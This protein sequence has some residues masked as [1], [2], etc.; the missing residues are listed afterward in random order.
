L[1]YFP[2]RSHF[3]CSMAGW[4]QV[5]DTVLDWLDNPRSGEI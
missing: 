5:A 1:K 3:L 4:E 2:D